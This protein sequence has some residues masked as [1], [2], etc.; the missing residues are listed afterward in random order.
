MQ[1]SMMTLVMKSEYCTEISGGKLW[2]ITQDI[3]KCSVV[4]LDPEMVQKMQ[5]TWYNVLNCF[6]DKEIIQQ[7]VRVTNRYAEQYKNAR[8]NLFSFRSFVRSWTPVKKV[9]FTQF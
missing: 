6:F 9:K 5:V 4:I 2:T 8:G 7:I 3:E 1:L